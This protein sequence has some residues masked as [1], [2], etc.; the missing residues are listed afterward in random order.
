MRIRLLEDTKIQGMTIS[1]GNVVTALAKF[2]ANRLQLIVTSIEFQ[3]NILP[4]EIT[5]YDTDGQ[6]GLYV[7][8]SPERSALLK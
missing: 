5:A 1:K 4:V 6:A 3:G 2:Q 8:F 7:P